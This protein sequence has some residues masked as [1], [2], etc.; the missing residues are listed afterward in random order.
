MLRIRVQ[1]PYVNVLYAVIFFGIVFFLGNAFADRAS[2]GALYAA[3]LKI[4]EPVPYVTTAYYLNVRSASS[5]D[6]KIIDVVEK[7]TQLTVVEKL[8]NGWLKLDGKGY[9]HGG[10]AVP[11]PAK[12][13]SAAPKK[14][15]EVKI[16][17]VRSSANKAAK[18][19][20]KVSQSSKYDV[21]SVS[22][23]SE[24]DLQA[25]FKGTDL[26]GH[27]L[28]KAILDVESKYGINAYF[29][30]AVMRLES[31]NGS[32][33]ISKKRNNLFGLNSSKGYLRFETKVD[34]V[35]KF[36]QLI[37]DNYI[38]KGYTTIEKIGKKYCPPN[39]KWP[40]LIKSMMN[41]DYKKAQA[42]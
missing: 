18:K 26:A 39:S 31:G 13:L 14:S 11:A 16:A 20:A 40:S 21:K 37:S 4:P 33:G 28:E 32:S 29:T 34:S 35:E 27:G 2:A 22:G 30:V 15:N 9:V 24:S 38:G 19:T 42:V 5:A 1:R 6:S 23:L 7:G 17:S 36:G 12:T 41:S 3:D 10:Y 25:M 8:S